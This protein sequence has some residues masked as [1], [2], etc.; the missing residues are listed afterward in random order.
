MIIG[1]DLGGT[2]IAFALVD[3]DSG[4][5]RAR[6]VAPT[7]SQAGAADVL[8]RMVTHITQLCA[9]AQV[10]LTEVSG[11]GIGVPGVFDD[12]TGHTL[13][14]PNLV[15]TWRDIAVG[16]TLTAALGVPT[17]LINDARAFVLGEAVYGAGRGYDNVVGFTVGTG[18]G[19]GVVIHQ[20][21]YL[22]IDGTA[23]EFGHQTLALDGP[24]CG[25][26]NYGCLEAFASGP[27][28][29]AQA[30]LL[31]EQQRAPKLT[32]LLTGGHEL[33]PALLRQAAESGDTAVAAVLET[34][35]RYL[36]TGV[37]N[38]V[39]LFS[40]NAVIIGGSVANLGEPL[41]AG[42]Q[43]EVVTRCK[44]TPVDQIAIVPAALGGDAGVLGAACWAAHRSG[45]QQFGPLS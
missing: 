5:V 31:L 11:I 15:G 39:S 21:L 25:C 12:A 29:V 28:M 41:F 45:Q 20:Q 19:G 27:A 3:S 40:P 4:T 32:T 24:Q 37:A 13:F 10:A 43:R 42:L 8:A 33:T 6:K 22:G 30:R 7:N 23:G 44:A 16:P 14:L 1:I 38:V 36:G 18:I 26:G 35:Y 34:A 2:K 9:D 17:W